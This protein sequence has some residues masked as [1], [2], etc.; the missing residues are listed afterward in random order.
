MKILLAALLLLAHM[1]AFCAPPRVE[2]VDVPSRP[3]VTQRIL[4]ATPERALATLVLFAGGERPL[5][6]QKDGSVVWG[7]PSLLVRSAPLFADAGFK[8]AIVDL[9]SDKQSGPVGDYRESAVHAQDIAAV[10][11][12]L[13]VSNR[14]PVWLIGTSSG[15]AS[16]LNAAIRLQKGGPD[17]IVLTSGIPAEPGSALV[18]QLG[19]IRV[20]TLSVRKADPCNPAQQGDSTG[21]MAALKNAPRAAE[22][23][24][25]GSAPCG[26][27]AAH[28]YLGM[29]KQL[30]DAIA[31]WIKAGQRLPHFI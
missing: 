5:G 4:I 24:V 19:E 27:A 2:V 16:V 11:A 8:V 20:P 17:G 3:G 1:P 7:G 9:P 15:S 12:H 29:E 26:A 23:A 6:I 21:I 22:I 31:D 28:G 14:L 18:A 30:V 10:I 13:R 25:Q